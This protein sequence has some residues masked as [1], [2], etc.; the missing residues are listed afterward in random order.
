MNNHNDPFNSLSLTER[1]IGRLLAAGYAPK[2]IAHARGVSVNTVYTQIRMA[3]TKL[4]CRDNRSR[5]VAIE[6]V[7][8][9]C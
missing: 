9:G 4:G 3:G 8:R 1:E 5:T 7:R 2:E 6:L